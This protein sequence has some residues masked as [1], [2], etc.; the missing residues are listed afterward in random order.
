MKIGRLIDARQIAEAILDRYGPFDVALN[1]ESDARRIHW[2]SAGKPLQPERRE[3]VDLELP[4]RQNCH[5]AFRPYN[6]DGPP[7]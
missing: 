4:G 2:E 3:L 6:A 1:G 7:L 5:L